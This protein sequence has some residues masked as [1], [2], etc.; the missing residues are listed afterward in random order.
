MTRGEFETAKGII[1][2]ID[3]LE[4][5]DDAL[6]NGEDVRFKITYFNKDNDGLRELDMSYLDKD[7]AEA[8]KKAISQVIENRLKVYETRLEEL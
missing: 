7:S 6:T 8:I 3:F 4:K 2:S 5:I 1:N